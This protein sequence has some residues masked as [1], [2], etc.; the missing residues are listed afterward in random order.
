VNPADLQILL[1]D[2]GKTV[3]QSACGSPCDLDLDGVITLNDLLILQLIY[4]RSPVA[5]AGPDQTVNEGDLVTL[6]GSASLDPNGASLLY[7]WTQLAGPAVALNLSDPV[8]PTFVAPSVPVGGSTLS[9]QL[10]VSNGQLTST[11][12]MVN[13]TVKHGNKPPVADAGATQTVAEGSVVTLDG[14]ASYDPDGSSLNF[15]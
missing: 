6:N 4:N 10:S 13:I 1:L 5:N 8:Y 14:S 7:T 2:F 15:L 11:P 12:A 3:E 9:F